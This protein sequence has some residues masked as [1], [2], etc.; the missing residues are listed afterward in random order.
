M[1]GLQAQS[2]RQ[3]IRVLTTKD[4]LPQSFVSGLVQDA[5]GFIWVGTR[6]GLARYDGRQFTAL[7]Y[8]QGDTTTLSSDVISSLAKDMHQRIWIEHESGE[9]DCLTPR[10]QRIERISQRRLF[11]RHP[12]HFARRGWS[13][14]ATGNLWGTRL[15][16]G[17]WCYDWA[18]Q[19]LRH[20]TPQSHGLPNDTVR[21]VLA[22]QRPNRIWLLSRQALSQLNPATG[23]VKSVRLPV[24]IEVAHLP[25]QAGGTQLL[26]ERANGELMWFYHGRVMLF[27]PLTD[28]FRQ[29]AVPGQTGPGWFATGPDGQDYL[30]TGSRVYRYTPAGGLVLL[31]EIT[32]A[33]GVESLLV[34]RSGLIWVGTNAAGI[35]QL[36][37]SGPFVESHANQA[38]FHQDLCQQVFG[39]SLARTFGWPTTEGSSR[40]AS[41][42]LRSTYDTHNRCWIGLRY[43]VGY[44]DSTRHKINLLPIIPTYPASAGNQWGVGGLRFDRA[45]TLWIVDT[46]GYVATFDRRHQQW[47]PWMRANQLRKS[48]GYKVFIGDLLV[49]EHTVWLA[50]HE[51]GLIRIDRTTQRTQVIAKTTSTANFPSN[52]L[53]GLQ[54]D[55]TRATLLWIGSYEGL[56]CFDKTTL[57]SRVFTTASGLP[58]NTIYSV[59]SDDSG[60]L[61]LSTNK[62]LCRFHPRTHQ[63]R[64]LNT[65]DGLPGDEFNRFHHLRLPDGRLA[66]GGPEG[67]TIVEPRSIQNDHFQ[68]PVALTE[69]RINNQSVPVT[70]GKGLLPA[71]INGLEALVVPY[72]Q[73]TVGLSFAGLQFNQPAKLQYR[74]QLVGYEESW[75]KAG[76]VP[77]ATYTQLPPGHYLLRVNATNTTGQWSRHL[78]TLSITVKP[79]WWR[80]HLAYLLYS[81]GGIGLLRVYVRY[82]TQRERRAQ[83]HLAQQREADQLRLVDEMKTRFFAN[84]THEFR[85]PLT[86]ILSPVEALLSELGQSRYGGRLS[87]IERNAQLLLGLINQLMDLARLDAN[88]M[89]VTPVLGRPDEQVGHMIQPF[90]EA[91]KASHVQLLYQSEGL[92]AYWYDAPKLERIVMNLVANALKF[93]PGTPA[94]PGTVTVTLRTEAHVGLS[95]RVADTGIGITTAQ[96]PHLFN[97]FYQVNDLAHQPPAGTGIGLALV[98]ELVEL[99]AGQIRVE[100]Q[101]GRG[102]TFWVEL[103]YQVALASQPAAPTR[104]ETP[105]ESGSTALNKAETATLLLVEDNDDMAQFITQSLPP[106]YR[107]HRATDGQDGLEQAGRLMPDLIISDVMMP[108]LDG[109]ALCQ[110]LKTDALTDHIPILL[111]TAKVTQESRMQ[112]LHGGA[113]EYLTKP[114]HLPELLMR[115]ANLLTTQRRQRERLRVELASP[116]AAV[117]GPAAAHPFL[118]KLHQALDRHL[119]QPSFGVDALAAEAN[120]SRMQLH[121]KLKGL[122][123]LSTTEFMRIY[124]L[125]RAVPLLE[126]G[127]LVTQAAYA[128][129]FDNPSYFGQCFRELFGKPPSSYGPSGAGKA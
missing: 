56:I 114:F 23:Q 30:T 55:P 62:G 78:H 53:L 96:L 32:V 52:Q 14:D 50:T 9:I 126:Q 12:V 60:Y 18:H 11:A 94:H 117:T 47:I 118:E 17:V 82:R 120:L 90:T 13:V 127:L 84:I 105:A 1:T 36:D 70:P 125:Q 110:R 112:G 108:R 88:L 66:F 107:V 74:Y 61:W 19:T 81:L 25:A 79:P 33:S 73:N 64:T 111:L 80:T 38:G 31:G 37:G 93:T 104:A 44:Y 46:D 63:V 54:P 103:P 128:V 77:L 87:L 109:Y 29:A 51:H 7:H 6:N 41:Y 119:D 65:A 71:P 106:S 98:K 83:L 39:L 121:R 20:Y 27:D 113:D 102:T 2:V 3:P 129:G 58:D 124:R 92:D 15:I 57:R 86:L 34:D 115:V 21:G 5:D 59:V 89:R 16:G 26:H 4:G 76:T 116:T 45:E 122:T 49:D 95:L 28:Q 91:A 75:V 43:R 69:L 40:L 85:T 24:S 68:P 123:G 99:Q 22:S 8:Q 42:S 100:S 101:P 67:W 48:I 97:R 35:H 72:G 10:T